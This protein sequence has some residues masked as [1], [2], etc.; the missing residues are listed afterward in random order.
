MTRGV[1]DL[2][3]KC[4]IEQEPGGN[5]ID[6]R[7]LIKQKHMPLLPIDNL[8]VCRQRRSPDPREPLQ[9][10]PRPGERPEGALEVETYAEIQFVII[11]VGVHPG[12]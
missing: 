4:G 5:Q 11:K 1:G 9:R 7:F 12:N 6:Q 8:K 10:L 3:R 2:N